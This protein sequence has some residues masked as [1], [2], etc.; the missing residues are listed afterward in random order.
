MEADEDNEPTWLAV[1]VGVRCLEK[2][3][4]ETHPVSQLQARWWVIIVVVGADG[5]R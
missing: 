4:E 5:G 3:D 2:K 1:V